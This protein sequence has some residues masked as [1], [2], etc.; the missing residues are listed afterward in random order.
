MM[1]QS[2]RDFIKNAGCGLTMA[3][4]AAQAEHFGLLNTLAQKTSVKGGLGGTPSDYRALVCIYFGG[5]NDGNNMVIPNHSD[6]NVSGYP[7]YSAARAPQGLALAQ[8]TLLPVSVPRIGGLSYGLHPS[9]GTITGGINPGLHPLWDQ[10][11]LAMVTNIGTLVRPI[12]RIEYQ[13]DPSSR[14]RNLFSHSDQTNQHQTAR[15]DMVVLSGWG[16]RISDRMTFS[17]NPTGLIPTISS[18]SGPRLFT[19]GDSTQPLSL[20]P[21]PTPLSSIL[22]LTGYTG[23]PI[24]NARL[25]ALEAQLDIEQTQDIV[26]ASNEIHRE[27]IRISR[28]LNDGAEV[29]V[30]FPNTDIGNQLKQVARLI[31]A[32]S[33]LHVT[34][35]IFM[36]TLDG[37]D[38]HTA[39]LTGQG[40]L[41]G[42][43]SQAARAFYDEMVAQGISDKVTQFTM[44]DF[45][46][47]FNPGGAGTNVGSDHA[48]ANH[49]FVI[50]GGVMGGNFYGNNTSNGT[51]FP[52]LVN[53]GPD[54]SDSSNARGRWIP[55]T[56]VE[57]YA[58]T[59]ASW[60]GL[61]SADV[62]FVFPN[63]ANFPV[64]NL[65]F[66]TS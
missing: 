30:V 14:P 13:T 41:L 62:P 8:N 54:D 64:T 2:R 60:F 29:T 43:F 47:T 3:A 12:T 31:K 56:S 15:A 21:A 58:G 46:R 36:V 50:G 6:A 28:S 45:N 49:Q 18:I 5:G 33:A 17:S 25:T 35:Q 11:K 53:N 63:M 34:R 51:P 61:P 39:Q 27:A 38:T 52:T 66:M 4:M 59:L 55:T 22:A 32:R 44:T 9:F 19:V 23:T 20:G 1:K 40:T 42:R 7:A 26:R 24:A 16:G 37:F 10:G 57:Q 65:G 48:W